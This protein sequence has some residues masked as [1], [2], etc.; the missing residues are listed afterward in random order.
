VN[1]PGY[2][3]PMRVRGY[4]TADRDTVLALAGRLTAGVARWRD[5]A[6]VAAAGKPTGT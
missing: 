5:A 3:E 2:G 4:R 6:A 1:D